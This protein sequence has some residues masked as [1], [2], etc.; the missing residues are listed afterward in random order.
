LRRRDAAV[1]EQ[2]TQNEAQ[3]LPVLLPDLQGGQHPSRPGL[4]ARQRIVRAQLDNQA[5]VVLEVIDTG[6]SNHEGHRGSEYGGRR[7][8][9]TYACA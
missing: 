3:H 4:G 5:Q 8:R 2:L 6:S 7:E 1:F 9:V